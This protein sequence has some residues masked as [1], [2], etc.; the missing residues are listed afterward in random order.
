MC[1]HTCHLSKCVPIDVVHTSDVST[2]MSP[3][4]GVFPLMWSTCSSSL[5]PLFQFSLLPTSFLWSNATYKIPPFNNLISFACVSVGTLPLCD[6]VASPVH[7]LLLVIPY[8]M[9]AG[10]LGILSAWIIVWALATT[11][12]TELSYLVAVLSSLLL[13]Y[14]N[15]VLFNL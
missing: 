6:C 15:M 12:L 5:I 3:S 7:N 1:L 10:A 11:H 4:L 9:L 2:Y 8:D 14:F 13:M